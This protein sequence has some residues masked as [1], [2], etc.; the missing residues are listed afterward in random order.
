[1]PYFPGS[2]VFLV[3]E[4]SSHY[5]L[6][7]LRSIECLL[8]P[9]RQR[10]GTGRKVGSLRERKPSPFQGFYEMIPQRLPVSLDSTVDRSNLLYREICITEKAWQSSASGLPSV[11]TT[12]GRYISRKTP[13]IA[14]AVV[15]HLRLQQRFNVRHPSFTS[16]DIFDTIPSKPWVSRTRLYRS[17]ISDL[18]QVQYFWDQSAHHS[19]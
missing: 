10:H 11:T 6:V 5:P 17:L 12:F 2:N 8:H 16:G 15:P 19:I 4:D 18:T 7:S 13:T 3:A 9:P 1:M 14:F